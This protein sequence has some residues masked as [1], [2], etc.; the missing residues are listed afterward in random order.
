MKQISQ[1]KFSREFS[2]TN[3]DSIVRDGDQKFITDDLYIIRSIR[4]TRDYSYQNPDD[5]NDIRYID[6]PVFKLLSVACDNA[7]KI[8]GQNQ[9]CLLSWNDDN[10]YSYKRDAFR[11]FG[12]KD[13][14]NYLNSNGVFD[15]L[16]YLIKP[17]KL[18]HSNGNLVRGFKNHLITR[19]N[20]F[21]T[22]SC[23]TITCLDELRKDIE[24]KQS[25]MFET[26]TLDDMRAYLLNNGALHQCPITKVIKPR[27]FLE[28][29]HISGVR[30]YR[31]KDINMEDYGYKL[32]L[33]HI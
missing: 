31:S 1:L 20:G 10:L 29:T 2:V 19:L 23:H 33:I 22:E 9:I 15:V 27:E 13:C 3:P 4:Q 7:R 14:A 6:V 12:P 8:E 26:N 16:Y 5:Y 17:L 11:K 21:A 18:R 25:D 24:D 28:Y 30:C 32:S